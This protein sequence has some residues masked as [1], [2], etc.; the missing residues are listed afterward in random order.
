MP[1]NMLWDDAEK[2][3]LRFEYQGKWT[4][5]EVNNMMAQANVE[6]TAVPHRVDTIHDFTSSSSGLPSNVL[7][8]ASSLSRQIP[9]QA[10]MSVVVGSSALINTLLSIFT[11]VYPQFASRYKSASTLDAAYA[12]I[13]HSRAS[14]R[15]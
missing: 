12:L 4:W 6:L 10:G 8:H 9:A 7:S 2:S 11:K 14:E 15:T 5:E 1:V 3:I 13:E